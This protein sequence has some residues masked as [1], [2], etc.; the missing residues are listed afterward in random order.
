[1]SDIERQSQIIVTS[2]FHWLK[3]PLVEK[4]HDLA[5]TLFHAPFVVL[6][7]GLE[8]DPILNY[9][10]AQALKLWEMDWERLIA[11]PSRMTAEPM[12]QS[13]RKIF[14]DDV[15]EKGFTTSYSGIRI[16][17]T[18]K[19]FRIENATIFNLLD[20]AGNPAGQAATF[21]KWFPID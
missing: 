9:G 19:R 2:Y 10:N 15:K 14:L 21:N 6:S 7:H 11:T 4:S 20:A 3:K 17:S 1:M 13:A 18:G 16:S 8:S 12:E 5:N